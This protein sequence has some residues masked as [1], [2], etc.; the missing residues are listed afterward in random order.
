MWSYSGR[1]DGWES[2]DNPNTHRE[3]RR[4]MAVLTFR[5]WTEAESDPSLWLRWV[6]SN[7]CTSSIPWWF[8]EGLAHFCYFQRLS[9]LLSLALPNPLSMWHGIDYPGMQ[10]FQDLF[11]DNLSHR[12]VEPS[13]RLSRRCFCRI[14]RNMMRAEGRADSLKVLEWVAEHGP[15]L[16]QNSN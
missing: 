2:D 8:V 1:R 13:L 7:L 6:F 3:N 15:M 4:W 10:E 14:Y 16:F 5:Q 9:Y 11:L 12:M